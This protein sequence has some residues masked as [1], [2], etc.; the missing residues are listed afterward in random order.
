MVRRAES[1]PDS[2]A[3][4]LALAAAAVARTGEPR[5]VHAAGKALAIVRQ[6]KPEE[7]QPAAAS[8]RRRRGRVFTKDDALWEIVGIVQ[9]TGVHDVSSNVD[10]YLAEAYEDDLKR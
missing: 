8:K 5:V 3:E 6:D 7:E 4:E 10:R 2:S 9:A 1:I